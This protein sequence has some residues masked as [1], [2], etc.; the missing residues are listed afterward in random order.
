[1]NPFIRKESQASRTHRLKTVTARARRSRPLLWAETL[2]D[3]RLLAA[4]LDIAAGGALT[5]AGSAVGNVSTVSDSSTTGTGNYSFSDTAETITLGPA[6]IG[7]GWTGSGIN[8]V[9]GPDASVNSMFVNVGAGTD[10]V[11]ILSTT[12]PISV[13]TGI[14]VP[15]VT[16]IGNA[17]SLAGVVANIFVQ[18]SGGVG[19][20][21]VDGSA[22]TA[23]ENTQFTDNLISGA[24]PSGHTIGYNL[25]IT[26]ISF[27]AG[28][29]GNTVG[30]NMPTSTSTSVLNLNTGNGNDNVAVAAVNAGLTLNLDTQAGTNA[31]ALGNGTLAGLLGG[32]N[33][34]STGKT[35]ALTL[36]DTAGT[37]QNITFGDVNITG[38][39][40]NTIIYQGSQVTGITFDGGNGDYTL[41]VNMQTANAVTSPGLFAGTGNDVVNVKAVD[42]A[43]ATQVSLT[44]G[45]FPNH[46]VH[47]GS[48]TPNLNGSILFPIQEVLN[49][50]DITGSASLNV[51]DME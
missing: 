16:N 5:Y 33:F 20:L 12:D 10:T 2:E 28:S 42:S 51:S 29:G 23:A 30:V 45:T 13:D 22:D 41:N 7:L 1:M 35:T 48:A 17:G 24:L 3:R 4:T 14:G 38:A 43:L 34:A 49:V 21:T 25:G 27:S 6:A 39:S 11:N 9:T 36:N 46:T 44:G 32:E 50:D 8:M 15:D 47:V 18:D 31:V 19:S 37:G 40:P 26:S